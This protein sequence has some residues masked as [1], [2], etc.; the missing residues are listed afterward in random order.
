MAVLTPTFTDDADRADGALGANWSLHAGANERV[1]ISSNSFATVDGL[2]TSSIQIPTSQPGGDKRYVRVTL[3]TGAANAG[4]GPTPRGNANN[5]QLYCRHPSGANIYITTRTTAVNTDIAGPYATVV[6]DVVVVLVD[7]VTDTIS[8]EVNGVERLSAVSAL[9]NTS[10]NHLGIYSSGNATGG[11]Y[12]DYEHGTWVA[13]VAPDVTDCNVQATLLNTKSTTITSFT[14]D[15]PYDGVILQDVATGA[16]APSTPTSGDPDWV[17]PEPATYELTSSGIRDVYAIARQGSEVGN[18]FLAG[19][20]DSNI[21]KYVRGYIQGN[22]TAAVEKDVDVDFDFDPQ[23]PELTFTG[24]SSSTSYNLLVQ[25]ESTKNVVGPFSAAFTIFADDVGAP[26]TNGVAFPYQ[27]GTSIFVRIPAAEDDT[28]I[29]HYELEYQLNGGSWT[30]EDANIP[31]DE[32]VIDEQ[33]QGYV[34]YEFDASGLSSG[35][36]ILFRY[37]V[38]D[39]NT[40]VSADVTMSVYVVYM[41]APGNVAT[42]FVYPDTVR[43][44]HDNVILT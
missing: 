20:V 29:D 21:N 37:R 7:D 30:V 25:G 11:M 1:S 6:D 41:G 3:D 43:V 42:L 38:E 27:D 23:D 35:D 9:Y 36:N 24:L 17:Y 22:P 31:P 40:L 32:Y 39:I 26:I 18:W 12:K 13:D 14:V 16:G 28:G 10:T 34:Q 2:T 44:S 19:T 33:P 5:N 15:N 4:Q 8:V